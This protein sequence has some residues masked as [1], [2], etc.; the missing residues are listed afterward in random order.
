MFCPT[1]ESIRAVDCRGLKDFF[2]ENIA[3][4]CRGAIRSVVLRACESITSASVYA[5]AQ[6][7]PG[8]RHIDVSYCNSLSEGC[9]LSLADKC[10]LLETVNFEGLQNISDEVISRIADNCPHLLSLNIDYYKGL[11]HDGINPLSLKKVTDSCPD[12]QGKFPLPP[13][14][15]TTY[16]PPSLHLYT[17]HTPCPPHP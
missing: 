1:L 16:Q 7:C 6:E 4:H 3:Q 15:P 12:I 14:P 5:L 17:P 2:V 10:P 8:L 9:L 13:I 11:S